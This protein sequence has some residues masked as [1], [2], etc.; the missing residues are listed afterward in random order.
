[1]ER[2]GEMKVLVMGSGRGP[3]TLLLA[4]E[5]KTEAML[6]QLANELCD[7]RT[8]D[9]SIARIMTESTL[10]IVP[11]IPHTQPNCHDY[12]TIVPFQPLITAIIQR[13]PQ[14]SFVV[15]FAAG[16][17]KVRYVEAGN[18]PVREYAMAYASLHGSMS[19]DGPEICSGSES[20]R[21]TVAPLTWKPMPWRAPDALLIQMACCY[22]QRGIQHLLAE[23]RSP[24]LNLLTQRLQG[25][26]GTLMD[27]N[28]LPVS[29]PV[30]VRVNN[31]SY[32]IPTAGYF[33][34][35][36]PAGTF[37]VNVSKPGFAPIVF[38]V[39]VISSHNSRVDIHLSPSSSLKS[40]TVLAVLIALLI[41]LVIAAVLWNLCGCSSRGLHSSGWKEGFERLPLSVSG[42]FSDD[43]DSELHFAK[44]RR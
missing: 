7:S 3:F 10:L 26:S 6:Y 18:S 9:G 21:A 4:V 1:M 8:G 34:L 13:F 11:E 27:A 23:N 28:D 43:S 2:V 14:I 19:P 30:V 33:Q 24:L 40:N 16:G 22:E 42:E 44:I 31:R 12:G 32:D 17:L 5:Q 20:G 36:L 37:S 35:Y 29:P 25:I 15:L 39:Q 38:P 41:I